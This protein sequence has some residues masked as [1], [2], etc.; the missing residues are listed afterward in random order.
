[1]SRLYDALKK[2]ERRGGRPA[3]DTPPGPLLSTRVTP[4]G[5]RAAPDAVWSPDDD[6]RVAYERIQVWITNRG[7]REAPTRAV[8]VAGCQEGNGATTTAAA[9]AA[10]LAQQPTT[11]VLV[12]DANLRTPSLHRVFGARGQAGF[13]DLVNNGREAGLD[14]VQPSAQPNLFVLTT[15]RIPRSPLE[16]FSSVK[17]ARLVAEFKNQFD[18]IVFDAPPLLQFPD[19]YALAPHVDAVLVVVEAD[20]TLVDDAR[21]VIREL[22]R[23]GVRGPTGV[24]LNRQ[25]DYTPRVLRR[26]LHRTNGSRRP[27]N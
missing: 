25:R 8:M 9:L 24:I 4:P 6:L 23:A 20:R 19:G 22:E 12:V 18:F 16:N 13:S 5:G 10:T 11:R 7:P 14:Y 2:A 26:L 27:F 3:D 21:R 15:G 1:M 17:L